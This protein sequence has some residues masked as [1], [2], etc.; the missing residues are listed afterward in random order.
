M[1]GRPGKGR[2]TCR[3]G[4]GRR[5][6]DTQWGYWARSS[7]CREPDKKQGPGL[8]IGM[9]EC[10]GLSRRVSGKV[11]PRGDP[12]QYP[13]MIMS[14]MEQEHN[15]SVGHISPSTVS[16]WWDGRGRLHIDGAIYPVFSLLWAD[17]SK[18][19]IQRTRTKNSRPLLSQDISF[20]IPT[21]RHQTL[22]QWVGLHL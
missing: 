10:Q 21:A 2:E 8:V 3:L 6:L 15:R 17:M 20:V 1:G 11:T 4:R 16:L 7:A 18:R 19:P 9:I 13:E 12:W 22:C 14:S 5:H